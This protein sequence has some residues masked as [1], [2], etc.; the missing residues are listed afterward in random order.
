MEDVDEDTLLAK[1]APDLVNEAGNRS[2]VRALLEANEAALKQQ[3][4]RG[5]RRGR[6]GAPNLDSA[7]TRPLW[8]QNH[9]R[10]WR[11]VSHKKDKA[12][13]KKQLAENPYVPLLT[14]RANECLLIEKCRY[15]INAPDRPKSFDL[16]SSS[17]R[18][19]TSSEGTPCQLPMSWVWLEDP[20]VTS[21]PGGRIQFGIEALLLQGC[22]M[23]HLSAVVPG[24][25]FSSFLQDLGGNAFMVTQFA[26]FFL[27]SLLAG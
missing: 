23:E 11:T 4:R 19:P 26:I 2:V 1:W 20:E 8:H 22:C 10:Q 14:P 21:Q 7:K 12:K 6:G 5:R 27:A 15:G 18:T 24:V 13:H 17:G 3:S 25:Y 16:Q 9:E